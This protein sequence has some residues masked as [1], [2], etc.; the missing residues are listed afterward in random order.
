ML[1]VLLGDGWVHGLDHCDVVILDM[2][3]N[4][5]DVAEDVVTRVSECHMSS[6][7]MQGGVGL[8]ET[9]EFELESYLMVVCGQNRGVGG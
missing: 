5:V 8:R 3:T 7:V 1:G 4:V 6:G 2:V 9:G